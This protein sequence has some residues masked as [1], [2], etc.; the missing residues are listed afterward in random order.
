MQQE[1]AQQEPGERIKPASKQQV[2]DWIVQANKLLDAKKEVIQKSFLVCGISN[3]LDGS[4]NSLIH[5]A[6]EL[7]EMAIAYGQQETVDSQSES[8]DPFESETDS[9]DSE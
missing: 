2:I 5:C 9:E 3:A 8:D 7:P 1:V 4:Q 6:K